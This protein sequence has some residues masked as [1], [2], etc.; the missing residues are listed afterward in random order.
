GPAI[1]I[2]GPAAVAL[3]AAVAVA[4]AGAAVAAGPAA[5][6]VAA[7]AA[8][9]VSAATGDLAVQP[10]ARRASHAGRA[11]RAHRTRRSRRLALGPA[12][13]LWLALALYGQRVHWVEEAGTAERDGY[14]GQAELLLAGSLPRDPYRPL[15]YPLLVA[16][17]A[18]LAGGAFIAARLLSN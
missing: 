16:A 17:V 15:L 9:P 5:G 12:L 2:A 1:A 14:V 3:G 6:A 13:L 4:A 10:A 7:V 11:H 8:P 18:P